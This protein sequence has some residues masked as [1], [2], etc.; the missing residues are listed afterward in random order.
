MLD[1][2]EVPEGAFRLRLDTGVVHVYPPAFADA[3]Q[4]ARAEALLAI[5]PMNL[6][7]RMHLKWLDEYMHGDISEHK[8]RHDAPFLYSELLR[9]HIIP[10]DR[11]R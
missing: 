7:S 3:A 6:V 2:F 5:L 10:A 1:P 11:T 8:L 9:Q 4:L